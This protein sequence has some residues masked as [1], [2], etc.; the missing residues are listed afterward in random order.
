MKNPWGILI[1]A[2]GILLV[3]V[4][5][6]GSQHTLVAALTGHTAAPFGGSGI[7]SGAQAF[8]NNLNNA[9]TAPTTPGTLPTPTAN[10]A[11]GQ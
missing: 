5:V 4:G 8:G 3:I 10:Q 2:L 6:K 7:A 1:T 11:A 9:A